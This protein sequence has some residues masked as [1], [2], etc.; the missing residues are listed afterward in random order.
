MVFSVSMAIILFLFFIIYKKFN[1]QYAIILAA[2]MNVSIGYLKAAI[3]D[4][5]RYWLPKL[6]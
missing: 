1:N 6:H 3:V 2:P 5:C 4:I